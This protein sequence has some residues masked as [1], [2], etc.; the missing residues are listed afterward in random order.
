MGEKVRAVACRINLESGKRK[1]SE[2]PED[3]AKKLN[4]ALCCIRDGIKQKLPDRPKFET[5]FDKARIQEFEKDLMETPKVQECFDMGILTPDL[6]HEK[7]LNCLG[8]QR[9]APQRR[10]K[11]LEKKQKSSHLGLGNGKSF[12]KNTLLIITRLTIR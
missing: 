2:L 6:L 5:P 3:H 12:M 1:K 7:V 8:E 4:D 11:Y 10:A 9:R